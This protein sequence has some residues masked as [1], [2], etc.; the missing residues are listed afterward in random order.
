[1]LVQQVE[2][3]QFD[4]FFADKKHTKQCVGLEKCLVD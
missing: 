3:G 1:M 4:I 2:Y